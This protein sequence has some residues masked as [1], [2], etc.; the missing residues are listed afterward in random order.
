MESTL[1]NHSNQRIMSM[2]LHGCR[3]KMS[4]ILPPNGTS[5]RYSLAKI[6]NFDTILLE[7][8]L[9]VGRLEHPPTYNSEFSVDMNCNLVIDFTLL[10]P[11]DTPGIRRK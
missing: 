10:R 5:G 6:V 2:P 4:A 7:S 1:L 3:Y 8:L 9:S 11:S